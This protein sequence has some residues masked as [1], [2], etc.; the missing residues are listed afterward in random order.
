MSDTDLA[1]C[2]PEG[3]SGACAHAITATAD[4]VRVGA[5]DGCSVVKGA[6]DGGP[7]DVEGVVEIALRELRHRFDLGR[8]GGQRLRA[9]RSDVGVL[10]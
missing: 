3:P 5:S 4:L 6:T 1:K 8:V 2:A 10:L 9:A 7:A